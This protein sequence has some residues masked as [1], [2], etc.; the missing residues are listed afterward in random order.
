MKR[1][2]KTKLRIRFVVLA[3]LSLLLIQSLIVGVS[4][5]NNYRDLVK[6]SDMLISQLHNNPSGAS[7]YFSV[8]I[9]AGKDTVYPDVVQHV[10]VTVEEATAFAQSALSQNREKLSLPYLSK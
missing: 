5:Y 8:K 3:I 2:L 9:P 7:R 6:K 4:I 10:S 1:T